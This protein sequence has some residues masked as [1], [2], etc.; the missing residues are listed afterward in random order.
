MP[1]LDLRN[2]VVTTILE[3][4]TLLEDLLVESEVVKPIDTEGKA[5]SNIEP[6]LKKTDF[7]DIPGRVGHASSGGAAHPTTDDDSAKEDVKGHQFSVVEIAARDIFGE[8]VSSTTIESPDFVKIWNLLDILSILSDSGQ[9]D[10]ALLF[11]LVEELLDS[12][13]IAGCRIV[14]DW[15]ESR[16]D[17]ITP[18]STY[19]KW[20]LVLLRICNELLRRLS[21]AEDNVFCGRVFIFVFQ[22]VPL[23]DRSSVNLQGEY[24]VENVT[25]FE[26]DVVDDG[27]KMD[28]DTATPTR[29]DK[30]GSKTNGDSK[31]G[32][33]SLSSDALYG[34]FWPLQESFSQPLTLFE[35]S[36]MKKFKHSV[37]QTILKF[38]S[39]P[40]NDA[41]RHQATQEESGQGLKRKRGDDGDDADDALETFNPK[42]L[43]SKDLFELEVNDLTFR[44][45][46]L[47]QTLII[48]NFILSW[49]GEAKKKYATIQPANKSVSYSGEFGDEDAKWARQLKARI[50]DH[51]KK[52]TPGRIFHRM[53][54]TVLSRDKNWV[55]WKMASCPT[56]KRDPVQAQLYAEAKVAA[57]KLAT[58]KRLRPVPL[59][60][61]SLDFLRPAMEGGEGREFKRCELPELESFKSIIANDDFD[62]SVSTDQAKARA[63]ASK[64]SK[65]WRALRIA[66]RSRLAAFDKIDDS[67]TIDVVFEE[68]R[69]DDLMDVDEPASDEQMPTNRQPIVISG[70]QGVGKSA[71]ISKLLETHK[72]V[73]APVVRHTTREQREGE[74]PGREFHFVK[75]PEFNQLRDGDRLIEYSE[76]EGVSYGTST[77]AIEAITD[78]GKVPII[79]LRLDAA[80]FAKDMYFEARYILVKPSS[81]E[82]LQGRL[83]AAG[84]AEENVRAIMEKLPEQLDES[85][86]V[87]V[88]GTS[89]INDDL[90]QAHEHLVEYLFAKDE[91]SGEGEDEE[92]ENNEV[93]DEEP[94]NEQ[95]PTDEQPENEELTDEGPVEGEVETVAE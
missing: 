74:V 17:R 69:D 64:A 47:V 55:Y 88:F 21:R 61:I 75:T 44:R 15:L 16:R 41:P 2:A 60:A 57:Q 82:T 30:A 27:S 79:E 50:A 72:G 29:S 46:I 51:M 92:A 84:T 81:P 35:P 94:K 58:S 36:S 9:C 4:K 5:S 85:K 23:G 71:L 25:T 37:E 26:T 39:Y 83:E 73:F 8:L 56:I 52:D 11:W 86:T 49:T 93:E 33:E 19:K 12:Q 70:P 6:P 80:Q 95:Q 40:P 48:L 3:V 7:N 24:H 67:N 43:T 54:D 45:H 59:G 53:V 42:Y 90:D 77:K 13:T 91:S 78:K 68:P 89:I 87:D 34:L 20:S 14:F 18:E 65:S 1:A 32:P 38:E 28:V 22:C 76:K 63:V 62:I 66:A 31:K 10:P